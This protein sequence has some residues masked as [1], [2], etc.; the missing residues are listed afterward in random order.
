VSVILSG[1]FTLYAIVEKLVLHHSP[2][3]FTAQLLVT[4]FLS[5]TLLLFLGIIGEYV[6]RI[7]EEVKGR[8]VYVVQ[9]VIGNASLPRSKPTSIPTYVARE[10]Q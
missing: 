7:Y 5:G 4:T 2:R 3:G 10:R 9:R 8:P 6:G 1:L